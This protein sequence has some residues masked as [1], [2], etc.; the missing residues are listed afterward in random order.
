MILVSIEMNRFGHLELD[1]VGASY[2]DK[3]RRWQKEQGISRGRQDSAAYLQDE[4]DIGSTLDELPPGKRRDVE[5]GW[6]VRVR[7]DPWVFQALAGLDNGQIKA[8]RKGV[9]K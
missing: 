4:G 3:V 7:M 8:K 6:T 1:P 9:R 5:E 2:A